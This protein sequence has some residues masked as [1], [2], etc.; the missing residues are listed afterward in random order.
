[1]KAVLLG[2][3]GYYTTDHRHT[4]CVL[5]PEL[6]L[7]LDA[8][9]GIYRAPRYLRSRELH[10]FLSH[11]HLDHTVGLS[12]LAAVKAAASLDRVVV[13]GA[14]EK[15]AAIEEHLF[16]AVL[17]PK[18]PVYEA[19][20]LA[21]EMPLPGGGTLTHFP[22]KHKGGSIGYRLQWPGHA[23]AYVT[24]TTARPDAD[25]LPAIRGVDLLLHEC[26]YPD[27]EADKAERSGHSHTSAVAELAAR[28]GVGK[29][30]FIHINPAAKDPNDPIGIDA[31]R[32]LFPAADVGHDLM[33]LAF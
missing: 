17:S 19:Q 15:L 32:K 21:A 31:A 1:M 27:D 5:L 13:Y 10:L 7:M 2:S 4:L 30:V 8:G 9:T 11:G 33:E 6:G 20:A 18:G 3:G 24:D 29:L 14:E 12:W 25:Y 23:I 28:A 22:L 26:Y 16:A